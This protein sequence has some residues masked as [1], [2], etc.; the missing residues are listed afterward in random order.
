MTLPPATRFAEIV[1][2][3]ISDTG[4]AGNPSLPFTVPPSRYLPSE[5][6]PKQISTEDM[7]ID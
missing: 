7:R 4:A 5:R 3:P 1:C 6:Y 2:V